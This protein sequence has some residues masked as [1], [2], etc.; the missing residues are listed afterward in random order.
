M[1]MSEQQKAQGSVR[2]RRRVVILGA[3]VVLAVVVA[4]LALALGRDDGDAGAGAVPSTSATLDAGPS[5]SGAT[6]DETDEPEAPAEEATPGPAAVTTNG[7]A[8]VDQYG[9]LTQAPSDFSDAPAPAAGVAVKVSQ[10]EKVDGEARLPGE[11]GGP[12]LRFTVTIDNDSPAALDLRTVVVNAFYG[13][14][15]TPAIALLGPGTEQF[16]TL[17]AGDPH[18]AWWCSTCRPTSVTSSAWRSTW[19][20]GRRSSSSRAPSPDLSRIHPRRREFTRPEGIPLRVADL[21]IAPTPISW[22]APVEL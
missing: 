1:S 11:V 13:A 10:V 8:T 16:P 14:D 19:G 21:S 22:R 12:S 9:R 7:E 20:W 18:K 4:V 3:V 17:E 2:G 5:P 6:Q 15:R